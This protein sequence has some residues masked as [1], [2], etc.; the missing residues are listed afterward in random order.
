MVKDG[1]NT[2]RVFY[3]N[4]QKIMYITVNVLKGEA[5]VDG[6]CHIDGVPG[7]GSKILVDFRD[8][9]GGFTGRLFPTGKLVNKIE[10]D[11]GTFIDVTI[12]D[13]VNV[14]GFFDAKDFSLGYNGLEPPNPDNT[15]NR[16]PGML[17]RLE[18]LRMKIAHSIGWTDYTLETISKVALPVSVSV[19]RPAD[20]CTTMGANIRAHEIDLVARFYLKSGMHTVAMGVVVQHV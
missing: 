5:R 17:R 20:N 11:D 4:T 18:E 6:G 10:M 9:A 7:A 12:M 13:M 2:I 15:F 16:P 3:T 1:L 8:Q 14:C 19:A